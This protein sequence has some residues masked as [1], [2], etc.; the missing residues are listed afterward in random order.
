LYFYIVSKNAYQKDVVFITQIGALIGRRTC[1]FPL[2]KHRAI[3]PNTSNY[4]SCMTYHGNIYHFR[5]D[6]SQANW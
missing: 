2:P 1:L 3:P 5:R 4:R 6:A